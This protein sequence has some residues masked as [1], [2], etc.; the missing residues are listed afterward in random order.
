MKQQ[1]LSI[2]AKGIQCMLLACTLML[3]P[4]MASAQCPDNNHPH[5][6]DLG[7]PSG[8]KW[9]CCNVGASKP[10]D[11]GG[12]FAWGETEEKDYYDW[13][14]YTHCD[15]TEGTCHDIGK[16]I[17]GTQYDAATA[18]WGSSWAM[19]CFDQVKELLDNC[20]SEW[21][22][23]NGV[24]GYRFTGPNGV[25]VFL[26]ASGGR[27]NDELV[28]DDQ[29]LYWSSTHTKSEMVYGFGFT[30]YRWG[31]NKGGL[32]RNVGQS[33][34]PVAAS[35][36]ISSDPEPYAVLSDDN[37]VLTFYY[38]GNKAS[39]NGM[40]VGPFDHTDWVLVSDWYD[41]RKSITTVV[42]DDSFSNCTTLTSTAYWFSDC[43]NLTTITGIENLKTDNVTDMKVMFYECFSLTSLDVSG[44]KT[45]NV[46]SME[47]MFYGCHSLK[48][49]DLSGFKTNNVT[50][51]YYMFHNCISLTTIYAGDGWSTE[52]VTDGGEMFVACWS[53]VGGKGTAFDEN[54]TDQ[55]YARIDK[56]GLPGY[57]THK[58]ASSGIVINEETFP[59]DNFRNW[60]LAQDY[61]AD[62]VLTEAEIDGVTRIDIDSQNIAD[63]KGIEYFT[64]LTQLWCDYNE[65]TSLDVSKNTAL[66]R[67]CCAGNQLTSLDVSQN[68]ALI[69]LYC[70]ENQI[71]ETEMGKLVESLPANNGELLVKRLDVSNEQNV[72]TTAQVAAA[73]AKGW[74]VL[75]L[76]GNVGDWGEWVD[77]DGDAVAEGNIVFADEAVKAL[78]VQNWD[79][80]G[81]GELSYAEAA[82]VTDLGEVFK[83]NEEITSF[84]ELQYFTGLTSIGNYA[85]DSCSGLSSI[86]IPN[87]VTLIKS[88][89][90]DCSG[91]TSVNFGNSVKTIENYAFSGCSSLSSIT[92]P[93]S[94]SAIGWG[95]FSGC[96]NLISL[97]VDPNNT[98]YDS[99]NN[100][101][102]IIE[103]A[104]NTLKAGCKTTIIPNNVTRLFSQAFR[105]CEGLVSVDIPESV[106][107][108][109]SRVFEGCSNLISINVD[110]N[111]KYYKSEDGV[112]FNKDKTAILLYPRGKT[113]TSYTIPNTVTSID[114]GAFYYCFNLTSVAIPESVTI[115][116]DYAFYGCDNLTTLN[117]PNN[118]TSI[119]RNAFFCC[120]GLTS[121]IIPGTVTNIGYGAFWGY[122]NMKLKIVKSY[123]QDPFSIDSNVFEMAYWD[124]KYPATLY[125]PVGTKEKYE[126]T[127]GW[128]VFENIVEMDIA[129][130][131]EG[132][133]V[134]IGNEIDENTNLDGNVV[135]DV[136]YSISSGD[137]NYNAAEG[138]LVVTK[139][140][141][142][143]AINGKDIFGDDFKDNYTG[144][145]FKVNEGKGSIKVE[146]ETQGNMVLK[147][148]IGNNDPIEMELDGKLKV[149]FPY[150]VSEPTYVYIYGG[151]GD[152]AGA[153]A[154]GGTRA[155]TGA[156]LLKIYGFE[157][158]SDQS[159]IETIGVGESTT[160]DAPVYNLS[161]QRVNKAG[162]GIYIKNGKKVLVK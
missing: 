119:G 13:S 151:L 19:P 157:V 68:T 57:F 25:S 89:F 71:N 150:N 7:L 155:S 104:T 96:I 98:I 62:G 6:I 83:N 55:T 113:E 115:I 131:D 4:T 123:I 50:N 41:Y 65:L 20:T 106:E 103:T 2:T 97:I 94:V 23:E 70:Y 63:L 17:A 126:S 18:T 102:A 147:V 122:K 101:N 108:I 80:N 85:F 26:P 15:G 136:Y 52:N 76:D 159:G 30:F 84:D 144:I 22:A 86:T 153:K 90:G 75:A 79:T 105:N 145:V 35:S 69:T 27:L 28:Y 137:G 78:C 152:S 60:V 116:G 140:T 139:P 111:N 54:H 125:V 67:L 81:D 59:D 51:M 124:G 42:F 39:R 132:Q 118:L 53:L 88:A 45:E 5:M 36:P 58:S 162:K 87:S 158:V 134:D 146:A 129:S 43:N 24:N 82:A 46:T 73:K 107:I 161:G 99:R 34:R 112:L 31:V 38:D 77:Y 49:L 1:H 47:G 154:T 121:V 61:G 21:T 40:S 48:S 100:C 44:F 9:A 74:Y 127:A 66:T 148:K 93:K 14:T 32:S 156:D 120:S 10:E 3:L 95:V 149:K 12:Y 142:D 128:N 29:G 138:C 141:D 72:I 110:T 133:T 33:V 91:L 109:D 64:A 11:Y 8:T 130:V 92:I 56:S 135:G 37:T 117:I 16:D 114:W 143:S 160:S